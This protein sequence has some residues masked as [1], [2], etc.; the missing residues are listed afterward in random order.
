[1]NRKARIT[2]IAILIVALCLPVAG[3]AQPGRAQA[4]ELESKPAPVGTVPAEP[5]LTLPMPA[6]AGMAEQAGTSADA[7]PWWSRQT[8]DAAN[9]VGRYASA[10]YAPGWNVMFVS[11][12]DATNSDLRLAWEAGGTGNCGPDGLWACYPLDLEGDRGRFNS[13]AVWVGATVAKIGI[14][15]YDATQGSLRY[16][17]YSTAVGQW[18]FTTVTAGSPGDQVFEGLYTSLRFSSTG[19][20]YIAFQRQDLNGLEALKLATYVGDGSGDCT[21]PN[22]RC[23]T[24]QI[25]YDL[26]QY[27]SLALDAADEPGVAYYDAANGELKYAY[28][29]GDGNCGPNNWWRCDTISQISDYSPF[30]G[31]GPHISLADNL[32]PVI[33]YYDG[34]EQSLRIAQHLGTGAGNCGPYN[35]W[36][37][38]SI[39]EFWGYD[40]QMGV[41]LALD[42]AGQPLIAYSQWP[43]SVQLKVAQPASR[44]GLPSG[45]CGPGQTWQ[46]DVVDDGQRGGAW[47]NV[48]EFPALAFYPYSGD[49]AGIAYFDLTAGDLLAARQIAPAPPPTCGGAYLPTADT[50][51]R[52]DAPDTPFGSDVQLQVVGSGSYSRTALLGFDLGTTIPPGAII[53]SAD[54]ELVLTQ[55]PSPLPYRLQVQAVTGAWSEATAT[56]NNGPDL[57]GVHPPQYH[58]DQYNASYP[59]RVDVRD[60]VN[61]W[62]GGAIGQTSI[63]LRPAAGDTVDVRI[64][65]RETGLLG[66]APRLVVRC[67]LPAVAAGPDLT[68]GDARQAVG[69]AR[70]RQASATTPRLRLQRGGALGMAVLDV[71]VPPSVPAN[72]LAQAQWFTQAYSDALRLEDPQDELQLVRWPL[73]S[74]TGSGDVL[75]FRQRHAGLPVWGAYLG[76]R[77]SGRHVTNVFGEYVPK[78]TLDPTPLL[79]AA[80]A[81]QVVLG[82]FASAPEMRGDT[83]LCYLNL[84]LIGQADTATHLA[85]QVPLGGNLFFVDAHSGALLYREAGSD[86]WN[87]TFQTGNHDGPSDK[88]VAEGLIDC[89]FWTWTFND[90]EWAN[91]EDGCCDDDA[92]D[93]GRAGWANVVGAHYFWEEMGRISPNGDGDWEDSVLIHVGSGWRNAHWLGSCG[94]WEFGDGYPWSLDTVGHEYTHA[95]TQYL[96]PNNHGFIYSGESGALS[97]AFS[98]IFGEFIELRYTGTMDW[99]AGTNDPYGD[100]RN[101]ADPHNSWAWGQ[102]RS[103]P[104]TY[105]ERSQFTGACTGGPNGNDNCGVHTNCTIIGHAAALITDGGVFNGYDMQTGIGRAKGRQ[106]FYCLDDSLWPTSGFLD[107]RNKAVFDCAQVMAGSGYQGFTPHDTCI[108]ARGFA[109]VGLGAGDIDCDGTPDDTDADVD[110]DGAPE[111]GGGNGVPGDQP[112]LGGNTVGCDDNCLGLANS[113]QANT[114]SDPMGDAC[115]PDDDDDGILDDGNQNGVPGDQPCTGGNTYL[116]DDNCPK[117]ANSLQ[118]D[119]VHTNGIGDACDNPDG[120]RLMDDVDMCPNDPGPNVDSDGDGRYDPCDPDVDDDGICDVGGPLPPGTPGALLGCI[121]GQNGRDNCRAKWN[122]DQVN[123]DPDS[124]GDACD[125]CKSV[126]NDDQIDSE[127]DGLGDACDPDDDN[128]GVLDDGD[129]SGV[130]GDHPCT[131]SQLP[132]CFGQI[133]LVCTA[134]CDD[135]CRVDANADQVDWDGDGIGAVCD[136]DEAM[137]PLEKE[138]WVELHNLPSTVLDLF[139]GPP[140]GF[141]ELGDY[142]PPG[143]EYKI[144]V[145]LDVPFFAQVVDSTGMVVAATHFEPGQPEPQH[146]TFTPAVYFSLP[147]LKQTTGGGPSR[148][149]S[150]LPAD[151]IRYRLQIMPAGGFEPGRPYILTIRYHAGGAYSVYLPL[152]LR[153]W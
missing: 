111:D 89:W 49:L 112:C 108:V 134:N 13:I 21:N 150:D 18:T 94:Y 66:A 82:Q 1:M 139:P 104:A 11:Y 100:Y 77:L 56:W 116:C 107:A 147:G 144:E 15:Y 30:S 97:E 31:E 80:D 95:I 113:S 60:L 71:A 115:D 122:Y 34:L 37:C 63:L 96:L 57:G 91:D 99:R 102:S 48:G 128:D 117:V 140:P 46:C 79:S 98:D 135:N 92:D 151:G 90:D 136:D 146:L 67:E 72:V 45:N 5:V 149:G 38:D 14:S 10:A 59:L 22:W 114:D 152:A 127:G 6:P 105:A 36:Q 93:E 73:Q 25:G 75:Y 12:Y 145:G 120:D 62:A 29:Y 58:A 83:Q 23:D 19:V 52:S 109:S 32:S 68:A 130:P 110:G 43:G 125:N 61:L 126:A 51:L 148:P 137:N 16:A 153:R 85:W 119:A 106:L 20:P 2:F 4:P 78:I 9:E 50:T 24:I 33:A 143:F 131:C 84:G 35:T 133:C 103:L 76:M 28:F 121:P 40:D 124:W 26:G 47:H 132:Q 69:L 42:S 7:G 64:A 17:E 141:D 54:L 39:E 27:A 74:Q 44:L 142:L 8:V 123:S 55:T 87:I 81:E 138:I 88:D 65:S 41:S 118:A 3:G 129:G 101:L 53:H 70:L 86:D